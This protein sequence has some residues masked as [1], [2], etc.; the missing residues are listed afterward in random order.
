[1]SDADGRSMGT[2]VGQIC[3]DFSR[4]LQKTCPRCG[5]IHEGSKECGMVM[6]QNLICRCE[7]EVH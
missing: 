2:T 5:H 7:Y 4:D 1:M 6:G 3:R